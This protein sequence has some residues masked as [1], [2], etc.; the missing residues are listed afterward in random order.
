LAGLEGSLEEAQAVIFNLASTIRTSTSANDERIQALLEDLDGQVAEALS[1]KDWFNKWGK[2]YLPSLKLAHLHQQCNNFKDPGVQHYA[3]D[4]FSEIRDVA[5]DIFLKLPP[6][7]RSK[8]SPSSVAPPQSMSMFY[9]CGG[10]CFD[11]KCLVSMADGSQ[12]ALELVAPGDCVLTPTGKTEIICV[13]K[14]FCSAGKTELVKL[15]GGLL[16]TPWHPVRI[17]GNWCFPCNLTNAT[18]CSCPAVYNLVLQGNHPSMLI[19][20][21]ECSVLGH[22]LEEPIVA[23]EFFGTKKILEDLQQMPGWESGFVELVPG[24]YV[25]DRTT[26]RVCGLTAEVIEQNPITFS[27]KMELYNAEG[28]SKTAL[29]RA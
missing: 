8:A 9:N 28:S 12:K 11:G 25:R 2:H 23:H 17:A 7:K 14:T 1:R 3:A 24:N 15:P 5:D 18:L 13:V 6:P 16:A 26:G 21:V 4:F 20:G 19:S 22:G 29:I 27:C 10:G